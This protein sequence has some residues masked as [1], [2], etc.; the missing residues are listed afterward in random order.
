MPEL[1]FNAPDVDPIGSFEVLPIGEYLVAITASSQDV[2]K[3]GTGQL[4]QFT[5]DV[6]DGEYKGR[7][8]FERLNVINVNETA[9]K[10]AQQ[11]LSA[12]CYV[13]GVMHPKHSEELHG[14]PF[15]VRVG[16]RPAK[17]EYSESNNILEY[18]FSDGRKLKD[19]L[20]GTKKVE[21]A[22]PAAATS[23]TA[24]SSTVGSSAKGKRPWEK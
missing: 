3:K 21:N 7:K 13:T 23:S 2:N 18:K 22:A 1:N 20:K 17:G 9:Q 10:I 19:A 14:K 12:I 4:L 11:S 5:F 24:G 8:L 6:I 16:I 15:R